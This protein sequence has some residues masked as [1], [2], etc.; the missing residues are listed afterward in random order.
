MQRRQITLKGKEEPIWS[1]GGARNKGERKFKKWRRKN[2]LH[3]LED[4][5]IQG[6]KTENYGVEGWG[7]GAD[8]SVFLPTGNAG[9]HEKSGLLQRQLGCAVQ[10]RL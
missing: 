9:M 5:G 4:K 3:D 7:W 2:W 8:V 1:R 10:I 6:R